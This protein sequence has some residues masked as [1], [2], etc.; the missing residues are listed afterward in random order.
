MAMEIIEKK[1]HSD[2]DGVLR[3]EAQVGQPDVDCTVVIYAHTAQETPIE[4][5]WGPYRAK[6]AGPGDPAVTLPP[7]GPEALQPFIANDLAGP[8]AS[9]ILTRDR[10]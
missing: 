10:R 9:E 4:D 7:A 1:A 3:V 2:P 6:L 5:P 8:A